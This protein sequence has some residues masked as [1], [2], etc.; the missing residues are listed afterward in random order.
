MFLEFHGREMGKCVL[1]GGAGK[2][3]GLEV[4]GHGEGVTCKK[5]SW[6]KCWDAGPEE[7]EAKYC[8]LDHIF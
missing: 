3:K 8:V 1:K 7:A 5:S 4:R 6:V 2:N